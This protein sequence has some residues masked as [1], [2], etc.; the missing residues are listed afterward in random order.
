MDKAGKLKDEVSRHVYF[1]IK[2][3]LC[4]ISKFGEKRFLRK[5]RGSK[6]KI[7]RKDCA[8]LED[9]KIEDLIR[10]VINTN[11]DPDSGI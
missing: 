4:S 1:Q 8:E 3:V 10:K 5:L 2:A 9:D 7:V 11:L 6:V